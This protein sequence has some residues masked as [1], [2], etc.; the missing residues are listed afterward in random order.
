MII[1]PPM[2]VT[3]LEGDKL[4][5]P[6][7]ARGLPGNFT[8]T[9]YRENHAVRS[10][11]WLESRTLLKRNGTLVISPIHSDDRGMYT[12]EVTNGIGEPQRASAFVEVECESL[13][14]TWRRSL[15]IALKPNFFRLIKSCRSCS[16]DVHSYSPIFAVAS[17]GGCTVSRGSASALPVHHLDQRQAHL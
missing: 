8:V 9:W 6:C 2:N 7:E 14:G 17:F 12:C 4:E 5:M 15:F 16:S 1:V 13:H 3:R 10:I 11:P